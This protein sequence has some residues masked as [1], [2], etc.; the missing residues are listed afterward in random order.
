M[1]I[2]IGVCPVVDIQFPITAGKA[3]S[4]QWRVLQKFCSMKRNGS[5]LLPNGRLAKG[6]YDWSVMSSIVGPSLGSI[7]PRTILPMEVAMVSRYMDPVELSQ[8]ILLALMLE[9]LSV[10]LST[11]DMSVEV[12]PSDHAGSG[13][14]VWVAVLAKPQGGVEGHP[15]ASTLVGGDVSIVGSP[16]KWID[17]WVG[18]MWRN[19]QALPHS[20]SIPSCWGIPMATGVSLIPR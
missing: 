19:G 17:G 11:A 12:L 7:L 20:L 18:A 5:P 1:F 10:I 15:T 6:S 16:G 13:I 4:A 2:S 3:L 14:L 9:I 8:T